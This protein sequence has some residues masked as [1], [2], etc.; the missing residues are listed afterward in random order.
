MSL[1]TIVCLIVLSGFKI[2]TL[3]LS[4]ILYLLLLYYT[5]I[6]NIIKPFVLS[7]AKIDPACIEVLLSHPRIFNQ[8][9]SSVYRTSTY[10]DDDCLSEYYHVTTVGEYTVLTTIQ[11]GYTYVLSYDRYQRRYTVVSTTN[12]NLFPKQ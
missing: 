1:N 5:Y 9:M 12:P 3:K 4:A 6:K 2:H 11:Y 10:R 8:K 7:W